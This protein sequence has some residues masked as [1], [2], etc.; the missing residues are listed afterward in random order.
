MN[1]FDTFALS[2][3]E[4]VVALCQLGFSVARRGPGLT[5]LRSARRMVL[6]PDMLVLPKEAL[7]A[8]LA[9][10]DLSFQSL[11]RVLDEIPTNPELSVL[12]DGFDAQP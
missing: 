10:A 11:V 5:I 7:D 2:G 4:C 3:N 9:E 12:P 8:I 6:V 1:S